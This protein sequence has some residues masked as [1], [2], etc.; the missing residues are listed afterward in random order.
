MKNEGDFKQLR[1]Q[2]FNFFAE[3]PNFVALELG[4]NEIFLGLNGIDF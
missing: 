4:L 3:K 2:K 1:G